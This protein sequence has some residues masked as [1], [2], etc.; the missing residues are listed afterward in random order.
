MYKI[1]HGLR[2]Q[3]DTSM[4]KIIKPIIYQHDKVP[5]WPQMTTSKCS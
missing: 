5:K 2:L 4:V 3:I 1:L